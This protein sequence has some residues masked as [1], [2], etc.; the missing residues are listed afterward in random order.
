M[1]YWILASG[2]AVFVLL[3][4]G[5]VAIAFLLVPWTPSRSGEAPFLTGPI[6]TA[7]PATGGP[8]TQVT[9]KGSGFPANSNVTI[10]L[11]P[12]NAG[13]TPNSYADARTDAA[14]D[15]TLT[16]NM[17]AT[18]PNG[19]IIT[20]RKIIIVA[21]VNQGESKGLAEFDYGG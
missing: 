7:E 8:H 15:F 20:E 5:G 12:P 3:M 6:L 19:Q 18:L 11:G 13:A 1:R 16:F 9:L 2:I 21:S 17:P 4:A 10:H 14:G